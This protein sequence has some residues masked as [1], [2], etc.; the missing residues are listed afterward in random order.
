MARYLVLLSMFLVV[1]CLPVKQVK[2]GP[3]VHEFN[4]T[5]FD[6]MYNRLPGTIIEYVYT[7]EEEPELG[8][9]NTVTTDS[10]GN[11]SIKFTSNKWS[12][13][14]IHHAKLDYKVRRDGFLAHE[15]QVMSVSTY[16]QA[17]IRR[18]IL[19][20]ATP[21]ETVET[22]EPVEPVEHIYSFSVVDIGGH[23]ISD[24]TVDYIT[25]DFGYAGEEINGTVVPDVNGKVTVLVNA[26]RI[27]TYRTGHTTMR[28]KVKKPLCY[29]QEARLEIGG[30]TSTGG[31]QQEPVIITCVAD[32]LDPV[33]FSSKE[34]QSFLQTAAP[35][36][37]A[38]KLE[39]L[40]AK[41]ELQL[42]S[43]KPTE[44]KKKRWL[45]FSF[46]DLITYNSIKFDKYEV[47]IN[48]Y[49][50]TVRKLM[51]PLDFYFSS[52][53]EVSGYKISMNSQ[54][55]NF[56]DKESMEKQLNYTF[57]LPKESVGEYKNMDITGQQL[58]DRSIIVYNGERIGLKLQ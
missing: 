8:A 48:V 24:A 46:D 5:V 35:F 55:K 16:S 38:V 43:I 1:S 32:Y 54:M 14:G 41:S 26:K 49:D 37:E 47:A 9:S 11:F 56:A 50:E 7:D 22:V 4:I 34:G 3:I 18:V 17:H 45:E 13:R 10:V 42:H 33:F 23:P 58:I 28:Y 20:S 6:E 51:S 27:G 25:N 30:P 53:H 21:V 2:Y 15:N 44:F 36:I 40:L 39:G 52:L 31:E 19:V 29:S 57:Y 12:D